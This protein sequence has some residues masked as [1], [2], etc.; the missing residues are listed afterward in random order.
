M[1]SVVV[2]GTP[3]PWMLR[4]SHQQRPLGLQGGVHFLQDG[5]IFLDVLK[6]IKCA[7]SI[8][9]LR[10]WD[11]PRIHLHQPCIRQS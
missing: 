4:N 8:K 1:V 6:N 2:K 3:Q 10:E 5:L 9:F 11:R 7:D